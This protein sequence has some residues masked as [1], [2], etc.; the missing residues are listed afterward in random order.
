MMNDQLQAICVAV[1][2]VM[3]IVATID[4]ADGWELIPDVI[5]WIKEKLHGRR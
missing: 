4:I 1:V 3:A 2:V 5:E